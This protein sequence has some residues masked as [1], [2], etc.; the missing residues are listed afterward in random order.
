VNAGAKSSA[1]HLFPSCVWNLE[2]RGYGGA[3]P[4]PKKPAPLLFFRIGLSGSEKIEAFVGSHHAQIRSGTLF[5]RG[6]TAFQ[7]LDFSV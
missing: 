7:I 6:K 2:Q 3:S 5:Q 4:A 1:L